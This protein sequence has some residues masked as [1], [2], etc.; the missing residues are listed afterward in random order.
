MRLHS[1]LLALPVTAFLG[2]CYNWRPVTGAPPAR[3]TVEAVLSDSGTLT[4]TPRIGPNASTILGTLTGVRGD[5]FDI[6]VA[7][8]RTR[9][10][11]SYYLRGTTITLVRGELA[12]LRVRTLDR[13]RTAI[14]STIAILGA[15][16]IITGV[17]FGGGGDNTGGGGPPP[18]ARP[19]P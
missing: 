10:G 16:A 8:V 9:D 6:A 5:T 11:L 13:R 2:G 1:L 14:A 3:A 4:L 19:R 15:G 17:R 18:A 12:Q 7:E